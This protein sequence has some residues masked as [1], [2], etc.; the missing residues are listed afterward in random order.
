V[1]G[2]KWMTQHA[3]KIPV[4]GTPRLAQAL[5]RLVELYD[6]RGKPEQA[7]LWR[8]ELEREKASANPAEK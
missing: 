7:A 2:Y 8:R 4:A 3:A 1:Q 5:K 6:A